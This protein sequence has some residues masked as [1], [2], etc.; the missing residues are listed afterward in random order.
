MSGGGEGLSVLR[1]V[2]TRWTAHYLAYTRLLVLRRALIAL[3]EYDPRRPAKEQCVII[4]DTKA[5][6]KASTM[7]DLINDSRFWLALER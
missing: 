5:Q 6:A 4:G 1:A 3:V 2:V 7:V